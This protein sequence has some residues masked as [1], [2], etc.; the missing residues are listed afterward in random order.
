MYFLEIFLRKPL[1][2]SIC[3]HNERTYGSKEALKA[4]P[5]RLPRPFEDHEP[6][7]FVLKLEIEHFIA[8]Y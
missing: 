6:K 4:F 5:A 1:S 7:K 8:I 3:H 2:K